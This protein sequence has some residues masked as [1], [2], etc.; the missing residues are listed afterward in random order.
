MDLRAA[1]IETPPTP[2][3]PSTGTASLRDR[4]VGGRDH[5]SIYLTGVVASLAIVILIEAL[6]LAAV[7][8]LAFVLVGLVVG[9]RPTTRAVARPT[10]ASSARPHDDAARD[11]V[12]IVS[13]SIGAGHDGAAVE[14][15]RQ[16]RKAGF[17][18][19]RVD[20]LDLLPPGLGRLVR[21]GY[22]WQITVI[23]GTWGLLLRSLRSP[24]D[25]HWIASLVGALARKR[26]MNT[27]QPSTR[28]IVSTYPLASQALSQ[29]R[30]DGSLA[31]PA[32]TY[33]TDMSVHPL[34]VASDIDAH[35]ALH[36]V[37]AAEAAALGARGVEVL[38]PQT[39]PC[40]RTHDACTPGRDPKAVRPAS[41]PTPGTRRGRLVGSGRR[42]VDGGRR[43][44]DRGSDSR[45]GVW[46]QPGPPTYAPESGWCPHLRMGRRHGGS[47]AC[48][49]PGDPERRRVDLAGGSGLGPARDH[50]SGTAGSR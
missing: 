44:R 13:A 24:S 38:G 35:V 20:F 37:P 41:R 47:D 9:H 40:F 2:A 31:I 27:C 21:S 33:L 45:R 36:A 19:D 34:W 6:V 49:R 4:E 26:L 3:R 43:S 10:A 22:R 1:K 48:T 8:L 25:N 11:H 39:S 12:L 50:L 5:F 18:V 30:R 46:E 29:L 14:L 7:V 15:A 42:D 28:V 16:A 23:P 17:V 32:I